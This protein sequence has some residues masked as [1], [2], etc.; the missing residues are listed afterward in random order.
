MA[1]A[2]VVAEVK[3]LEREQPLVISKPAS[4]EA[5]KQKTKKKQNKGVEQP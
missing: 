3:Q 1:A 2:P 5:A 4:K